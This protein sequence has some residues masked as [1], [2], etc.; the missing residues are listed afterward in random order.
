MHRAVEAPSNANG[1][2]KIVSTNTAGRDP[3]FK[4][5]LYYDFDITEGFSWWSRIDEATATANG[6][7]VLTETPFA[8]TPAAGDFT[9]KSAYK[10]YGDIRW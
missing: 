5:N 2:P 7:A 9:V 6:G 4:G 3:V 8:G 10:G 1:Y